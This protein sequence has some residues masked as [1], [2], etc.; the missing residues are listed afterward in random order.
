MEHNF[1]R[2]GS[3][4]EK[5]IADLTSEEK[6]ISGLQKSLEGKGI[7]LHRLVLTGYLRALVDIGILKEKEIKPAR[8]YSL[9]SQQ[10]KDIYGIVGIVARNADEDSAGDNA[11]SLLYLLFNRPIFVRELERCNVELPRNYRKVA[12]TKRQDYIKKLE[13]IGIKIPQ[14]NMM[15]EPMGKDS[16]LLIRHMKDVI[17]TTFD[18]KKY[19]LKDSDATQS[20]LD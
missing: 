14:N 20:T 10:G 4:K 17:S 19:V 7:N 15:M 1:A 3:L 9:Q 13:E 5:I 8:I 11:L 2:D 16:S 6:S 12:P 18:L